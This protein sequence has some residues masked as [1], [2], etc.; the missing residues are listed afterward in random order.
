MRQQPKPWQADPVHCGLVRDD[1]PGFNHGLMD[2][3]QLLLWAPVSDCTS[4][5]R[6]QDAIPF[7][8]PGATPC[9]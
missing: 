9:T 1:G 4:S 7:H 5:S 2:V 6:L 3:V 8:S